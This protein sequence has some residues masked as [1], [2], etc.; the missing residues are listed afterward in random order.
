MKVAIVGYG[1]EGRVNY[2]YYHRAGHDVTIVDERDELSDLPKQAPVI[3]GVGALQKLN[4]FDLI[5]R[6]PGIAPQKIVTDGKM[7]SATNEFFARC[8]TPIIGVTGSKG[9]G[10]TCSFITEI[11]RAAG[12]KVE[13]VGNIGRPALAVLD[14]ANAA[15][16]VVYELSSFQ[17]WD[18]QYS[19]HVGVVLHIEP[20]HLDV[21]RSFEDYLEAKANIVRYMKSDDTAIVHPTNVHAHTIASYCPA[22]VRHYQDA[23][24]GLAYVDG[25]FFHRNGQAICSVTAVTLPGAHNLDNACAA[26][27][28]VAKFDVSDMA[29]EKGLAGFTGLPHRL[30]FVRELEEVRYYDDSIATT[31]GSAIA[32]LRAFTEPKVLIL[33]GSGKG[34][35]YQEL[36][37]E[38]TRHAVRKLIL[39][40]RESE[41]IERALHDSDVPYVRLGMTTMSEIVEESHDA[42]QPGDVVILS[43]AAA[44]FDMFNSYSDRGDQFIAA[45]NEL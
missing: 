17:L 3:L 32:A 42:A 5:I 40:G 8:T 45:V 38:I 24:D 18:S 27:A 1:I 33:G 13:L 15:D 22:E 31:P 21:H 29:I 2:D 20:D 39:V 41:R 26:I 14:E 25:G 43:P 7:W 34:A 12:K 9:K 6:T 11:L 30:K 37:E 35:D 36:V 16:I 44:S 19:P 23:S 28:A 4:G 10:T